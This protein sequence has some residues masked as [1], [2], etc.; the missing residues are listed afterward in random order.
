MKI[1]PFIKIIG[2]NNQ[3]TGCVSSKINTDKFL[4][5]D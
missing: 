2:N 5:R 3:N 4:R 1:K